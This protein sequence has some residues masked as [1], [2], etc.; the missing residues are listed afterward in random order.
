[1]VPLRFYCSSFLENLKN[2]E[3]YPPLLMNKNKISAQHQPHMAMQVCQFFLQAAEKSLWIKYF[4][5]IIQTH[6]HTHTCMTIEPHEH[7]SKF[8]NVKKF[9]SFWQPKL[10]RRPCKKAPGKNYRNNFMSHMANLISSISHKSSRKNVNK[11]YF[12]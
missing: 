4:M 11:S 12:I 8:F 2:L 5:S 7:E 1:M 3:H 9:F 10:Q 6:T